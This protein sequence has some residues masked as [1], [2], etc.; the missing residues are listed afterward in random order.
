MHF[1]SGPSQWVRFSFRQRIQRADADCP[2]RAPGTEV[3][4]VIMRLSHRERLREASRR[5]DMNAVLDGTVDRH[6]F[7]GKR[8]LVG[9][10]HPL[11]TLETRMDINEQRYGFE[12]HADVMNA[13]LNDAAIR[14]MPFAAQWLM[15]LLMILAAA[16]Y[17]LWRLG[18]PHRW[19]GLVLVAG[20]ALYLAVA[21][22][23]YA[24]F[25]LLADGLYHIGA[26]AG[27]W[28][29]LAVL[30]QRWFHGKHAAA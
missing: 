3:A 2:A 6:V 28:W 13:L 15:A 12:F 20:C 29:L 27:T 30:E 11:D 5:F 1:P 18:K 19:D 4:R 7:S 9:A 14:P 26:F 25:Q 22:I 17:R 10:E 21:V 24:K 23:L 8:V 16:A